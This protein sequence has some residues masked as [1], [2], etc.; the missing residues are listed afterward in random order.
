MIELVAMI[1]RIRELLR[2]PLF[3]DIADLV[4]LMRLLELLI[5]LARWLWSLWPNAPATV[6]SPP[7]IVEASAV[8]QGRSSAF[9]IPTVIR[10]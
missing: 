1:E 6:I 5:K 9:G 3:D 7:S 8:A 2:D 10:S 4:A